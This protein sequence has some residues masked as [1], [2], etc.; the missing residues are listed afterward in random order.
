M[1]LA[2]SCSFPKIYGTTIRAQD[3]KSGIESPPFAYLYSQVVTAVP[4]SAFRARRT[5]RWASTA[6]RITERHRRADMGDPPWALIQLAG[7][8]WASGKA[9]LSR[10]HSDIALIDPSGCFANSS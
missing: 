1:P 9:G 4:Q 8:D 10:S 6:G 3:G 2:P 5:G 7:R